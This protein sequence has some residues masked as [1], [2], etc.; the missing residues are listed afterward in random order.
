MCDRLDDLDNKAV[1]SEVKQKG[2]ALCARYPVY[3]QA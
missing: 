3:Q 1:I 2:L